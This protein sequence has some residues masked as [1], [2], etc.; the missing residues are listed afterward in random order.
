MLKFNNCLYWDFIEK[1]YPNYY[2]SDE[3]LLSDILTRFLSNEEISIKDQKLIRKI[4][5]ISD[6]KEYYLNLELKIFKKALES[7][8]N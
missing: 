1:Y 6:I 8:L 3:I 5:T 7:Y 4:G 2:S